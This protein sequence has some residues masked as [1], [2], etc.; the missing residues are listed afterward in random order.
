M[1]STMELLCFM[2]GTFEPED[3]SLPVVEFT[4]HLGIECS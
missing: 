1:Y 2:D 3:L 4:N